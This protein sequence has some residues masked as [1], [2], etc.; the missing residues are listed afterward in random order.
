MQ[1]LH[2]NYL[3]AHSL[4]TIYK[5]IKKTNLMPNLRKMAQEECGC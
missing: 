2:R 5:H 3:T 1:K 4:Q